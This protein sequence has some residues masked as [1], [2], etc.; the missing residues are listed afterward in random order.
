MVAWKSMFLHH[1]LVHYLLTMSI[2][3]CAAAGELQNLK[4]WTPRSTLLSAS[5]SRGRGRGRAHGR[6]LDMAGWTPPHASPVPP[7][8]FF[9]SSSLFFAS[10]HQTLP[11]PLPTSE[12]TPPPGLLQGKSFLHPIY[13]SL[14]L[15]LYF[16]IFLFLGVSIR[17]RFFFLSPWFWKVTFSI[18]IRK[19]AFSLKDSEKKGPFPLKKR[20]IFL[21]RNL[22]NSISLEQFANA[23]S[24]CSR[25]DPGGHDCVLCVF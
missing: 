3:P 10:S 17:Q 24:R 8:L 13:P 19:M 11:S 16:V 15:S 22:E 12:T 23:I 1:N 6:R 5:C 2:C 21:M 7:L 9:S 18:R 25:K 20:E 14:S 4:I